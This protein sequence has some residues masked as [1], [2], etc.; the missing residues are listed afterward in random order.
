MEAFAVTLAIMIANSIASA[1]WEQ[2]NVPE[3]GFISVI[4]RD[5]T[6]GYIFAG[7]KREVST[8]VSEDLHPGS[9][10]VSSDASGMPGGVYYYRLKTN[11]FSQT[12]S[13]ILSK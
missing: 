5:P 3:G 11:T 2:T 13:M 6:S 8:L 9:Y 7:G 1:Q 10:Q 12:R 4:F